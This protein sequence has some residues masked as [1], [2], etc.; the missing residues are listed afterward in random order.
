[1]INNNRV[2]RLRDKVDAPFNHANT[3][4]LNVYMEN[5]EKNALLISGYMRGFKET[6]SNLRINL[7]D[8]N[9]F[10]V[11]LH[12]TNDKDVKYN[13]LRDD[14][15]FIN[16]MLHPI[17]TICTHDITF[18]IDETKNAILN[19]N[20][21]FWLLNE[22]RKKKM[23]HEG[24]K[25]KNVIKIR[26]D[27][28]LQ[29][30]IDLNCEFDNFIYIPIDCKNNTKILKR[31]D[32][33]LCDAI[34]YGNSTYMNL[35]FDMYSELKTLMI[36]H[37]NV[38]EV[39]L[40]HYLRERSIQFKQVSIRYF[41]VLSVCNMIAISGDSGS[42]KTT[43]SNIIQAFYTDS[44]VFECDRYHKWER[45]DARWEQYSHLDPDANY[46]LKMQQDVFDL[47]MGNCVMQVDYDHKCGKFTE[48]ERVDSRKNIIVCG[49]HSLT[50]PNSLINC[51]IFVD[52]DKRIQIYWKIKR[53]CVSRG[54][55]IES[56]L[57]QMLRR[58]QDVLKH[59]VPQKSDADIIV[60]YYT[61][62]EYDYRGIHE[63]VIYLKIGFKNTMLKVI[64][65]FTHKK[66]SVSGYVYVDFETDFVIE[67]VIS[68]VCKHLGNPRQS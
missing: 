64:D 7:L 62:D 59:I 5:S 61:T 12:I 28:N 45:N 39:L 10:D 18:D 16:D 51:K 4:R 40:Y 48:V 19:Q 22:E 33:Y 50:L 29:S 23:F 54:Y 15:N 2:S 1:M 57:Q 13:N 26:P 65:T 53:D 9:T 55:D 49:L 41:V 6:V 37:T 17:V 68:Q 27:L 47:K 14:L 25:Y 24:V 38:N 34:A 60:C 66:I 52:T 35:Y 36:K 20:Y 43:I 11:Y 58:E 8:I 42:G 67:H 56:V 32:A 63:P 46:I 30:R 3:L 44:F 21:K 31:D